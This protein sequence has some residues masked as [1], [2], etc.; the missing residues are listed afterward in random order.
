MEYECQEEYFSSTGLTFR[1]TLFS[2]YKMN[3]NPTPDTVTQSL[4]YVKPALT[5]MGMKTIEV[6][7]CYFMWAIFMIKT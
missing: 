1:H 3:R 6:V 7:F 5:A 4:R 2:N